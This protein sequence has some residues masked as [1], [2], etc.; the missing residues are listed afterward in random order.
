MKRLANAINKSKGKHVTAG[1]CKA[2]GAR[3]QA[4]RDP[5]FQKLVYS[6][7]TTGNPQELNHQ[8]FQV[9]IKTSFY[10]RDL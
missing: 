4:A 10:N 3:R 1:A 2:F 7:S 6:S 9:D 8:G 5:T